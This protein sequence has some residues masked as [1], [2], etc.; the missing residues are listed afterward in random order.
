MVISIGARKNEKR[1]KTCSRCKSLT[2]FPC[3]MSSTKTIACAQCI[4]DSVPEACCSRTAKERTTRVCRVL[5]LDR[6]TYQALFQVCFEKKQTPS[7]LALALTERSVGIGISTSSTSERPLLPLPG[8]LSSRDPSYNT[9]AASAHRNLIDGSVAVQAPQTSTTLIGNTPPPPSSTP[10]LNSRAARMGE[11]EE[12]QEQE[13]Q[14]ET[15]PTLASSSSTIK[16]PP[17]KPQVVPIMKRKTSVKVQH[18]IDRL[19][20]EAE[21]SKKLTE[22]S[23]ET[24]EQIKQQLEEERSEKSEVEAK[25]KGM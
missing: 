20:K 4:S 8:T 3:S 12:E 1:K 18:E 6:E 16:H 15:T 9:S 24:F 22:E 11:Q 7:A 5:N 25:L 17:K 14:P 2:N 19:T 13:E 21:V 10:D 23:S